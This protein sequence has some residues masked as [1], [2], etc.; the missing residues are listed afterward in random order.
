MDRLDSVELLDDPALPAEIVARAYRELARTHRWL[1]NRAAVSRLLRNGPAPVRSVLDLGCGHGALL[2]SLRDELGVE[3]LGMD[4]RPPP[5]HA[6]VRILTGD[7]VR[8]PLPA[9]DVALAV[10]LAHHLTEGEIVAL[11]QNVSRSCR[12]LIVLDLVRH[13]L[14]LTLFR[15]CAPLVL[16]RLNVLDGVT[17]IR[18]AFTARELRSLVDQAVAGSNARV[19]HTV[20]PFLTRQVLDIRWGS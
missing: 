5:P 3:V 13:R 2:A 19:V 8:D 4:S 11:V 6:P 15:I 12:R 9:A 16:Q 7:A 10:C 18:R 1:G 20:T 14:P 17:S